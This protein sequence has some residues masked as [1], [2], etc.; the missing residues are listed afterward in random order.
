MQSTERWAL[1]AERSSDF[2][3]TSRRK[4]V[5]VDSP[6]WVTNARGVLWLTYIKTYV[7]NLNLNCLKDEMGMTASIGHQKKNRHIG[8][9][10]ISISA[11]YLTKSCNDFCKRVHT[12]LPDREANLC[13]T[14][15]NF[16]DVFVV[17]ALS[18]EEWQRW[19]RTIRVVLEEIG[20]ASCRERV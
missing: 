16:N 14:Y 8:G 1:S 5:R 19:P 2:I 12:C 6:N 7:N 17:A 15:F 3:V 10:Q 13:Y 20:R 11:R 4:N 9:T 18:A